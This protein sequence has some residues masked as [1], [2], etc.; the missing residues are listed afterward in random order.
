M[1]KV[2]K[3]PTQCLTL[4]LKMI[5]LLVLSTLTLQLLCTTTFGVF[6]DHQKEMKQHQ[7]QQQQGNRGIHT[8]AVNLL[9]P[10]LLNH[11]D[12]NYFLINP[13][14]IPLM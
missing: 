12:P 3:L 5:K 1:S 11:H 7:Q 14:L 4:Q 2:S 9:A 13:Y 10:V 8:R 6:I